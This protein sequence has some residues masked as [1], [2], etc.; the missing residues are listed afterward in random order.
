MFQMLSW[1][2]LINFKTSA[3][4]LR[5]HGIHQTVHMLSSA[6]LVDM[7]IQKGNEGTFC[8]YHQEFMDRLESCSKLLFNFLFVLFWF[9]LR[10][11]VIKQWG[12]W[13]LWDCVHVCA[14]RVVW[15]ENLPLSLLLPLKCSPLHWEVKYSASWVTGS[16]TASFSSASQVMCPLVC[17]IC[18]QIA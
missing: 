4:F 8:S 1:H 10:A 15:L 13:A 6:L 11:L 16:L 14:G 3:V 2:K 12:S 18:T 9:F 5:K 7:L 17:H